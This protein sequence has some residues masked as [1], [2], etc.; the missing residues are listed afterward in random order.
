[1]T[2]SKTERCFLTLKHIK[3]CLRST[4]GEETLNT[5]TM[6]NVENEM[7]SNYANFFF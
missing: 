6:I 2:S 4:M 3:T 7:I 5:L 1:M